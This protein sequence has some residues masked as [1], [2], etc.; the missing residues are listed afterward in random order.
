MDQLTLSQLQ[1]SYGIRRDLSPVFLKIHTKTIKTTKASPRRT[2]SKQVALKKSAS[3]MRS[4]N[5]L[6]RKYEQSDICKQVRN[7]RKKTAK[8][9]AKP[10]LGKSILAQ[11]TS[12]NNITD[13]RILSMLNIKTRPLLK[14]VITP[15]K[16]NPVVVEVIVETLKKLVFTRKMA[17]FN[18]IS[19]CRYSLDN[20]ESYSLHT[21]V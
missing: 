16:T 5:T 21:T 8:L 7:Q 12:S 14:S 19:F 15:K 1:Q 9:L 13:K 6:S 17:A 18:Q 4:K 20:L 3:T 11:S 2:E 10:D